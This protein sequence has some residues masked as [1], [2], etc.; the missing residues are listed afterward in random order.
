MSEREDSVGEEKMRR[1]NER[2]GGK[3][4]G[5][6]PITT[7]EI[8]SSPLSISFFKHVGCFDFCE[9]VQQVQNHP[10]LT[11]LFIINIHDK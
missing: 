11:R 7:M 6:E 4:N 5:F 9:R 2:K 3:I 8:M 10:E 1:R